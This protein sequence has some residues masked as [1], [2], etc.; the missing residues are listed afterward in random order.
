MEKPGSAKTI[1]ETEKGEHM[2]VSFS[3]N[4]ESDMVDASEV[5]ETET[6]HPGP[7]DGYARILK[8]ETTGGKV[9]L[10]S[11]RILFPEG[12]VTAILGPSGAGKT[13]ALKC[14]DRF[15]VC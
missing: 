10:N 6:F 4:N 15:L 12:S 9:L 2:D 5:V 1:E 14:F 13:Y 7:N 3:H 11:M 8:I